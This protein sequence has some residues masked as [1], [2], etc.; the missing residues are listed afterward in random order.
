M[1]SVTVPFIIIVDEHQCHY[2][3]E[4]MK[5][6]VLTVFLDHAQAHFRFNLHIMYSLGE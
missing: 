5:K 1:V 2:I 6:L 4:K 3:L